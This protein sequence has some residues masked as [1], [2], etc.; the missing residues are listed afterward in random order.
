MYAYT[1]ILT[2]VHTRTYTHTD[3]YTNAHTHIHMHTYTCTHTH[4]TPQT[5][6]SDQIDAII[7]NILDKFAPAT[8]L[9]EQYR[10]RNR[11]PW[12]DGGVQGC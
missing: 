7:T 4:T 3:A 12:Y 2:H 5:H 11:Q 10:E 1:D 6:T 9:Q 8:A